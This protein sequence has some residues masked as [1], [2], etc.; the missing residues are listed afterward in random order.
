MKLYECFH[1]KLIQLEED[2]FDVKR[3]FEHLEILINRLYS[4]YL[5]VFNF[6]DDYEFSFDEDKEV[7]L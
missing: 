6:L 1:D 5:D 7:E 2:V 3:Q 4:D